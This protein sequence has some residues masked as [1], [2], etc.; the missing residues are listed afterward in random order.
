MSPARNPDWADDELILALDLYLRNG[1]LD[2]RDP[3]VVELSELLNSLPIHTTRPDVDRFR[4]PNGVALKLANFSALDPDYPGMGM[5]RGGRHDQ[6]VWD[7]FS[8]HR[9]ELSRL[10]SA[11]RS[12][13]PTGFPPIPEEDE[14]EAEEGR[15]LFRRHR[16]YERDARLRA[17]K[18]SQAR[19]S[20][21][22]LECEACGFDFEHIYGQL[23]HDFIECHHLVPLSD[24]GHRTTRLTD[25]ALLCS[26]CHRMA[27]RHRP[28]PSVADLRLLLRSHEQ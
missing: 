8:T 3:R 16:T 12:G 9:D 22:R 1:L 11:I 24:T 27:H 25:L 23:G 10:A 6:Q 13:A 2:D 20:T 26:N 14:T 17:K 18:K 7:R 4:N 5:R 19:A 28:W 21:G 15:L